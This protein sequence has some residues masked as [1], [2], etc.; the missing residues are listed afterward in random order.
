MNVIEK[1]QLSFDGT[2]SRKTGK[3]S[4]EI[5]Q[6]KQSKELILGFCG[7]AGSDVR[8]VASNFAKILEREYQYE[9]KYIKVSKIIEQ[10]RKIDIKDKGKRY[11]ALQTA[12]DTLRRE[13]GNNFLAQIVT[14]NIASYRLSKEIKEGKEQIIKELRSSDFKLS[15]QSPR[16]AYLI[17][18]F[19]HPDE[20]NLLRSVYGNIFYTVGVLCASTIRQKRLIDDGIGVIDATTIMERD[21]DEEEDYGQK[22]SDTLYHA[23]FF[24]R[25]NH[26]NI[27]TLT[28]QLERF[29]K[30]I[31]DTKA[32]ITPTKDEYAMYM[33]ES[34]ALKSACL[35]RQV[36]ASILNKDGELISTGTNDVPKARGG[37]YSIEDG[38]NDLRCM[39]KS[40]GKCWNHYYKNKI[41]EQIK[42]IL[43]KEVDASVN[44]EALKDIFNDKAIESL[45]GKISST[46][47]VRDLT[48]FSR[49]VHA[50]M[51]AITAGARKG[52]VSMQDGVLYAT[53]FP[54]HNCARHIIAVGIKKVFYI[55]PYEK[56]LA[57]ELYDE[58]IELDPMS[59]SDDKVTFLHF[60]GVAPRQYLNL[61]RAR[62]DRKKSGKI[63]P[64]QS[65][66]AIPSVPEYLATYKD[67]EAKLMKHVDQEFN[68]EIN[69][70][71]LEENV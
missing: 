16:I 9:V 23:D 36:G 10:I 70:F 27:Q 59:P 56:S 32:V 31:L 58:S 14:L 21:R 47:R 28:S 57:L 48:E 66:E 63:V 33:A 13:F 3:N 19:K 18:Q 30:L 11:L 41:K 54:C 62:G 20:L 60:E 44:K 39:N 6:E 15:K 22:L 42:T 51:D 46:T 64:A 37:L 61:F 7:A 35:S 17:D 55:E 53:L 67:F 43:T 34:A 49:S 71:I 40:D 29:L 2:E 45:A 38:T 12:G 8:G 69:D 65:I 68:H 1:K 52:G 25:N 5:F 26:A 24:I 4:S 50:E